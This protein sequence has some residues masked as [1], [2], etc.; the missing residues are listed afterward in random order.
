MKRWLPSPLT[1]GMLLLLWLL[2]NQSLEAGHI[3]LG[4]MLAVCAP[5]LAE[6]FIRPI[7]YPRPAKPLALIRLLRTALVEI[8]H[9]TIT[10]SR[11]ILF[12]G[13]DGPN[14][15]FIRIPLDLRNPY[16]L[17][18]LSCLINTIPGTVWV[19]LLPDRH[20]LVMHVFDLHDEQWWIDTIKTH[21]E[22]P[23]IDIFH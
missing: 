18:L 5:L 4:A 8:V 20:E 14:S 21:Y 10:V 13:R 22:K 11:L 19:E 3:L 15:Q 12:P 16:G 23:I 1:S 7:G 6:P 2:L 9:S 17:A